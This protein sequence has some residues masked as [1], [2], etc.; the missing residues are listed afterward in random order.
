VRPAG[1]IALKSTYRGRVE[2]DF[3]RLVVDEITLIGSRCGP[4]AP[5]LER[6]AGGLPLEAMVEA[7]YDLAAG[8]DALARAAQPG[9]LKVLLRP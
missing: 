4:F 1:T 8:A 2:L 6:L 5:A 3:A 9:A 7:R